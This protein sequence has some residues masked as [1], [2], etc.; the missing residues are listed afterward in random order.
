M[1]ATTSWIV[2]GVV[3]APDNSVQY[4]TLTDRTLGFSI[5][6]KAEIGRFGSA[7][8]TLELDNQDNALTPDAGGSLQAYEWF[9]AVYIFKLNTV[10]SSSN[11]APEVAFMV[12]TNINFKD[13][14]RRSTVV[15]T[16]S[17][18]FVY[19][20]R[21]QVT[22]VSL[23]TIRYAALDQLMLDVVNGYSSGGDSI[24]G[25]SFPRVSAPN[26]TEMTIDRCNNDITVTAPATDDQ[27]GYT[28][29]LKALERGTARDFMN[30]QILPTGPAVA[31]PSSVATT[32]SGGSIK[33]Q[34]TAIYL[35]RKL[36]RE[37]VD[38]NDKFNRF[39]FKDDAGNNEYPI[40]RA[41][42]QFNSREMVNQSTIQSQGD[43]GDPVV[44]NNTT[45]Q[46]SNGVRSVS[47][48]NVII[49]QA[50]PSQTAKTNIGEWWTKRF[51]T[52]NFITQKITT[53][54]EAIAQKITTTDGNINFSD[55]MH[56]QSLWSYTEATVTPTGASSAKTYKC[57]IV[58]RTINAT[59]NGT[60]LEFDLVNA[61]DNQSIKLDSTYIGNLDT[62]RLG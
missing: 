31:F 33:W 38:G 62:F 42:T 4:T 51:N 13:D 59:P 49:P 22:A 39:V 23:G 8:G 56:G 10:Y 54:V 44:S 35:N 61:I 57:V 6:Q 12:C 34:F 47:F 20:A 37:T 60:T 2:Q 48:N 41:D 45:S 26:N 25:V 53:T 29:G 30:N 40:M 16:L 55:L 14:G 5:N 17:D 21:D 7:R 50:D 36:T 15:L 28:G 52:V 32:G 9:N 11:L 43:A 19:A 58:G 24:T 27:I 3:I 46:Q 18:P 1:T